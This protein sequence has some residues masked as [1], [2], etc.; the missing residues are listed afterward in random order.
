[1]A[2]RLCSDSPASLEFGQRIM[3]E[4]HFAL[5]QRLFDQSAGRLFPGVGT[6][7]D[8]FAIQKSGDANFVVDLG[9]GDHLVADGDD[10]AIDDLG[11]KKAETESGIRGRRGEYEESE[12]TEA[13]IRELESEF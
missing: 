11:G 7:I 8:L 13:A 2:F 10:D 1:M 3:A 5:D 6:Q 12:A 4:I 9:L